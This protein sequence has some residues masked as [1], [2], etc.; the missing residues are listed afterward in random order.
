MKTPPP[1]GPSLRP[2]NS[3]AAFAGAW[4]KLALTALAVAALAGPASAAEIDPNALISKFVENGTTLE[5]HFRLLDGNESVQAA[6]TAKMPG[7]VLPDNKPREARTGVKVDVTPFRDSAKNTFAVYFLIDRGSP[8]RQ[9]EQYANKK[10][11]AGGQQPSNR[12]TLF[13][14]EKAFVKD[15]LSFE[16]TKQTLRLYAFGEHAASLGLVTSKGG[17][18][19][20][21]DS[22]VLEKQPGNLYG[23]LR[24]VIGD[25]AKDPAQRKAIVVLA[26]ASSGMSGD[27]TQAV[28]DAKNAGVTIFTVGYP[29]QPNASYQA[30]QVVAGQTGGKFMQADTPGKPATAD[31]K[32]GVTIKNCITSGG[33]ASV[34]ISGLVKDDV[35]ELELRT[36]SGAVLNPPKHTIGK[37]VEVPKVEAKDVKK[38]ESSPAPTATPPWTQRTTDWISNNVVLTA[39]I[40]LGAILLFMLFLWLVLRPRQPA[41]EPSMTPD[42][43]IQSPPADP[44]PGGPT[45]E[46]IGETVPFG[47]TQVSSFQD[48]EKTRQISPNGGGGGGRAYARLRVIEGDNVPEYMMRTTTLKIGRNRDQDLILNND[49]VSR[50]HA[51]IK[52]KDGKFL[53]SNLDANNGVYVNGSEV[54][55]ITEVKH[56]DRIELGEVEL[57]FRVV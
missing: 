26:T 38:V 24:E 15:F 51:V 45:I 28:A 31:P 57:E 46:N 43:G 3:R 42:W 48:E 55:S 30:L 6:G 29:D 14:A 11:G 39:V 10:G 7:P 41:Y 34:D 36:K 25:L 50:V 18:D 16:D 27:Y 37:V 1:I 35:V 17:L 22:L 2:G 33:V 8:A 40:V 13:G 52:R 54:T 21:V 4:Q 49:S 56:G 5:Y 44:F 19:A 32:F 12:Q 47:G 20:T 53:I 23:A 9:V